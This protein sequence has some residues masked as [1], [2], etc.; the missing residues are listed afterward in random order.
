MHHPCRKHEWEQEQSEQLRPISSTSRRQKGRP[1]QPSV[2]MQQRRTKALHKGHGNIIQASRTQARGT[3]HPRER[4]IYHSDTQGGQRAE[5]RSVEHRRRQWADKLRDTKEAQRGRREP[6]SPVHD[7][8]E[9]HHDRS[10]T[11]KGGKAKHQDL[12][13]LRAIVTSARA[14]QLHSTRQLQQR[15]HRN[16]AQCKGNFSLPR[17]VA[18]SE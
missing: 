14:S 7:P 18:N 17:P 8:P 3:Q 4:Q 2:T 15:R 9:E 6:A 12:R 11:G 1:T 10:S 16:Q 5:H 13:E